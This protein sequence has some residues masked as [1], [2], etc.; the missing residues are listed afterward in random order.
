MRQ[1]GVLAAAGSVALRD[2]PKL[3]A[4]DHRN[5]RMIARTIAMFPNI[6]LDMASVESNILYFNIA[7]IDAAAFVEF[8]RTRGVLIGQYGTNRVRLV[9]HYQISAEQAERVADVLVEAIKQLS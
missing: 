5:T 3:L 8:V 1:A 4:A 9:L 6:D 2:T 7:G